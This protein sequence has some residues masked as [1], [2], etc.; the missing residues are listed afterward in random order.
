MDARDTSLRDN[1]CAF[2][3]KPMFSRTVSGG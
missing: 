1:C 3:A 2:S